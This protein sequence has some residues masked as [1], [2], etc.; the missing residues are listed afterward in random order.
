MINKNAVDRILFIAAVTSIILRGRALYKMRKRHQER[1][2]E[3]DRE[4]EL[5]LKAIRIAGANIRK[6]VDEG[7][8]TTLTNLLDEFNQEIKLQ[9]IAVRMDV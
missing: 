1:L 6:R 2:A 8:Y 9:K 3:I 4:G 7:D 5:D